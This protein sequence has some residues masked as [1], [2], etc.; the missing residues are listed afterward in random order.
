MWNL[1]LMLLAC[2]PAQDEPSGAGAGGGAEI[3]RLRD[4][5]LLVGAITR[6]DLDGL[7]L[8]SAR[9]GGR[10]ALPWS[11]L[12]PGE[13][14]RLKDGFGYHDEVG[15]PM[16][17]ASR[18]L[19]RNGAEELGVI[20]RRDERG[21]ELR[22]R[23]IAKVIPL[24]ELAAPPETV[25][26]AATR[27]YTP[28]QFYAQRVTEVAADDAL[29]Q[30]DFARE[31]QSV[32]AL[33]PAQQHL[34]KAR[35]LA[36]ASGDQALLRRV[37]A[38]AGELARSLA[39][40]VEAQALED[41]REDMHRDRY[42]DAAEKLEDY[43]K[44]FPGGALRGEFLDLRGR[45]EERRAAAMTAFLNRNWYDTAVKY[46]K[47]KALERELSFDQLMDYA[48]EEVPQLVRKELLGRLREGYAKDLAEDQIDLLWKERVSAGAKRHQA[49][50][51][52]GTW[53]LGEEKAREGLDEKKEDQKKD[54]GKTAEQKEL[55]ERT[56]RYLENLERERRK[57]KGGEEGVTPEDW[58]LSAS[59]T[60]RFQWLLAYYA[61]FSG[62]YQVTSKAF[63][64]CPTCAGTGVVQEDSLVPGSG[65][66][67]RKRSACPTC[68]KVGVKRAVTFR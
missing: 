37:D 50:Y 33:E 67:Q 19:L 45:F 58:W 54:D 28:E 57:S 63:D 41:I 43:E 7:E 35:A 62:D 49:S 18:L 47:R 4:G 61:E 56:K 55:E 51:G 39:N 2:A 40:R 32:F 36:T 59:P 6:H 52:F 16:V 30:F 34:E 22:T 11:A 17:S 10:Y 21:V 64:A 60:E 5:R 38:A 13:A 9:D 25:L 48:Q 3:V 24:A 1:L 12:Y 42:A 46:L 8:V 29:A 15:V 14:Q 65:G 53:I 31:L 20:L 23:E 44:K 27:V 26:V 68:H 66:Q